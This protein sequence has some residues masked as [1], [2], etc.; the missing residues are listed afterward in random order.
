[1][2][3]LLFHRRRDVSRLKGVES[4]AGSERV[5][6]IL[7][8][9]G[10]NPLYSFDNGILG[11]RLD[12]FF[13]SAR[14]STSSAIGYASVK[15]GYPK[16]LHPHSIKVLGPIGAGYALFFFCVS[17]IIFKCIAVS[18]VSDLLEM[19]SRASTRACLPAVSRQHWTSLSR[20][21]ASTARSRVS[22]PYSPLT[23]QIK[24]PL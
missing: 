2:F 1:M 24:T 12:E 19:C 13:D 4:N 10:R 14:T 9:S 15:P 20:Y 7:E 21:S 18:N 11:R 22:S 5:S 3:F 23:L 16:E 17:V 8:G 6:R